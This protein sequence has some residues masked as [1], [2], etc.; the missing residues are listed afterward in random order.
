VNT[1]T[2]IVLVVG[3]AA[4]LLLLV[5]VLVVAVQ[6]VLRAYGDA[7][8]ALE[9]TQPLVDEI[10]DQQAVTQRELERI[11]ARLETLRTERADRAR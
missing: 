8:R 9:R 11:S 4:T 7:T 10:R 6:R 3:A 2:L 1:P 5:G